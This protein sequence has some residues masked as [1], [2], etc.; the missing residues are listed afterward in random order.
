MHRLPIFLSLIPCYFTVF[1]LTVPPP[2]INLT[3]DQTV[4]NILT[5]SEAHCAQAGPTTSPS[6]LL[7]DCVRAIRS[8]PENDY[9]GIFH[10]G[11][12]TSLWRLPTSRSY[13]SCTVLVILNED[14]DSEMGS[15]VDA[16][17]AAVRLLLACRLPFDEGGEQR[18]GGWIAAGAENGLVVQ[19]G[20]SRSVGI[21]G[22][23]MGSQVGTN[24][25][26]LE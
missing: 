21:N 15:W 26:D 10:I 5:N 25:V 24:S 19:L 1:A 9:V 4:P 12:D 14:F 11:G 20:R 3:G 17:E 13:D 7:Q 18:T 23:R 6:P 2:T 16:R 8:L 22:T